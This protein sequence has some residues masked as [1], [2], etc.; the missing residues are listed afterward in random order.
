M[1]LAIKTLLG[2]SFLSFLLGSKDKKFYYI[3]ILIQFCVYLLIISLSDIEA[4]S[5]RSQ[6]ADW[7]LTIDNQFG[8][9]HDMVFLIWMKWLSFYFNSEI[10]YFF[11]FGLTTL[12]ILYFTSKDYLSNLQKVAIF[13]ILLIPNKFFLEFSMNSM[14]AFFLIVVYF[15]LM[16]LILH[17]SKKYIL[18]LPFLFFIHKGM[19]LL[20]TATLVMAFLAKKIMFM[21]IKYIYFIVIGVF[22]AGVNINVLNV[23]LGDQIVE[24]MDMYNRSA[25]NNYLNEE[26]TTHNLMGRIQFFMTF[27]IPTI[28]LVFK[29]KYMNKFDLNML[30]YILITSIFIILV[31]YTV[32]HVLRI[33]S[34]IMFLNFFLF[35][36]YM[37]KN[38]NF[39]VGYIVAMFVLHS[40]VYIKGYIGL[41]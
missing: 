33:F 25:A 17:K 3:V 41:I 1:L 20:V 6:Y 4:Y 29:Q 12:L 40:M 15:G 34:L 2:T 30:Y 10:W 36:K 22:L 38:N 37:N 23:I 11:M 16:Y 39:E 19:F 13:F 28:F 26:E 24:L 32:P 31:A 21:K 35:I 5:D 7:F 14:R 9:Q 27:F 18:L 8:E